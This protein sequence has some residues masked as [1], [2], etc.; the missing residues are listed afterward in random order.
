MTSHL[1]IHACL[2]SPRPRT[3]PPALAPRLTALGHRASCKGSGSEARQVLGR[4]Y[5]TAHPD[6]PSEQ[7]KHGDGGDVPIS[8]AWLGPAL[9]LRWASGRQEW[10]TDLKRMMRSVV[11]AWVVLSWS[12]HEACCCFA[13]KQRARAR[14]LPAQR[15][16]VR[17]PD[18]RSLHPSRSSTPI[19][20]VVPADAWIPARAV[21][22]RQPNCATVESCQYGA[23]TWRSA[24]AS[25]ASSSGFGHLQG[26]R[27]HARGTRQL[28]CLCQDD[29]ARFSFDHCQ[30]GAAAVPHEGS[31]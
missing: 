7:W 23:L 19:L 10:T 18:S 4:S 31:P 22:I 15:G 16:L 14:Q 13:R 21:A 28:C 9:N 27:V 20:Y 24:A 25:H 17:V 8:S 5:H 29:S 30:A 2:Q 11:R 1:H 26:R 12:L 3:K 6:K